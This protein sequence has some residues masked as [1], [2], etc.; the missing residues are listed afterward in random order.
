MSPR[1][2][3]TEALM[4]GVGVLTVKKKFDG[5]GAICRGSV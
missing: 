4:A 5:H 1:D 2:G 3:R